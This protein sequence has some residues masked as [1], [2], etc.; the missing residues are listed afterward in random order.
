MEIAEGMAVEELALRLAGDLE[1]VLGL[2]RSLVQ[3]SALSMT[4]GA[5]LST[6]ERNGPCRLT[7]LAAREGV[8]QPAMTQLVSRLQDAGLVS[9]EADPT[10]GRVVQVSITDAGKTMLA[11]RRARRANGL[12]GVLARLSAEHRAA[13][14]NALPALDE[15]AAVRRDFE[16]A[17][18]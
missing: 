5:T 2:F 4:A 10:D 7:A 9:R 12:A 3:P 13:L 8:T 15:L 6:L 11:R 18:A 1:Q 16:P 17:P 14:A